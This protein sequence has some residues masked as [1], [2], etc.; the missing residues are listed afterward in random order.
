MKKTIIVCDG[1]GCD[2][3]SSNSIIIEITG[4]INVSGKAAPL[5]IKQRTEADPAYCQKCFN[6][7]VGWPN[8]H[9]RDPYERGG[10]GDR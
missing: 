1:K 2:K 3:D 6:K 10:P 4:P 8:P 7:I 5:F 9:E